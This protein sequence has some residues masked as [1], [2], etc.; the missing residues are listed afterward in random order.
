MTLDSTG[1]DH[2]TSDLEPKDDGSAARAVPPNRRPA[3][4]AVPVP[5]IRAT[6]WR[7]L[8]PPPSGPVDSAAWL[9]T[10][11]HDIRQP[12]AAVQ[13][14]GTSIEAGLA[15]DA[16][17]DELRALR[18][19]LEYLTELI[20][21]LADGQSIT[22]GDLTIRPGRVDVGALVADVITTF[23][24]RARELGKRLGA[25]L[26]GEQV[27]LRT[28]SALLKRV[29][30]NLVDNSVRHGRPK[31]RILVR[32]EPLEGGLALV[33]EDDG[34]GL[35]ESIDLH[36]DGAARARGGRGIGLLFCVR[37]AE[38]LGGWLDV[39]VG[40]ARVRVVIP[41]CGEQP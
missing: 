18:A 40:A 6:S 39:A 31:G 3:Y 1:S 16:L 26:P 14:S 28:D 4:G 12:L 17:K 32:L 41:E 33:V 20:D 15:G 35:P 2:D 8:E 19:G 34:A 27:E 10:M 21:E 24:P 9:R 5:N 37:A 36:A 38:A 13:I 22:T 11:V 30:C 23:Q 29:L 7:R 25:L